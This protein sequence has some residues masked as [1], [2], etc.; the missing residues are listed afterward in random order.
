MNVPYSW[1]QPAKTPGVFAIG[2][3]DWVIT[4]SPQQVH[5]YAVR[6]LELAAR[7]GPASRCAPPQDLWSY[8]FDTR[9]IS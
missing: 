1:G 3:G 4:W 5:P 2:G 6:W 7:M 8:S 9:N